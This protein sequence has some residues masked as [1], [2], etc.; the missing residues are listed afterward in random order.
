MSFGLTDWSVRE[1]PSPL[2][3]RRADACPRVSPVVRV[4]SPRAGIVSESLTARTGRGNARGVSERRDQILDAATELFAEQG[5]SDGV[6]QALADRLGVGKG[7]LYRYFPSKREL[8]LAAV[9]RVMRRLRERV[10]SAIV[11]EADPLD[12]VGLAVREF[13]A[14]FAENPRFVELL[15]QERALFKD[16]TTP[17][18]VV[19]REKN[20]GR[21]RDL[22]RGLIADQRI[23]D[24]PV[25]RVTDVISD[26]IYG[27]IFNNYFAGRQRP[28]EEQARDILDVVFFGILDDRERERRRAEVRTTPALEDRQRTRAKTR[29]S[30]PS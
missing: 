28:F 2:D 22:Y 6:T 16:R 1:V 30:K 17:T 13:L 21:W 3:Y 19:H 4:K 29:G 23:R 24:I 9:D 8:F 11:T 10:D 14:F 27:T 15:V 20:V 25:E 5:Y 12:Q 26:L 18:Y 7:T